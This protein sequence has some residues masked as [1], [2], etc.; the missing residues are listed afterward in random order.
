MRA[1]K[2][3]IEIIQGK[4]FTEELDL[5]NFGIN[6]EVQEIIQCI[7]WAELCKKPNEGILRLL[8]EFYANLEERVN[9]KV[10][11]WGKWISMSSKAINK[12]IRAPDHEEDE[13]FVLMDERV[14][15]TELVKK[16]C[17]DG[18]EVI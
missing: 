17:Q 4:Q 11:V 12:F 13:H 16:L 6:K 2:L 14:D 18:K 9:D 1:K 10:F 15:T 5:D 7:G 3:F 8:K